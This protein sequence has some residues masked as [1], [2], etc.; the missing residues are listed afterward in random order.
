VITVTLRSADTS[1]PI[2]LGTF[3]GAQ[4]DNS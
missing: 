1:T 3:V 2:S 4:L